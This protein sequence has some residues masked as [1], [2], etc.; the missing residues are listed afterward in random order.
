MTD[1][2]GKPVTGLRREDFTVLEDGQPQTL[3]AF[4][5]GDF[6]LSV[7]VAVD[8]SFSMG[9]KQLPTAVER[10]ADASSASCGRRISR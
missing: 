9:A 2:A 1:Q 6:P 3:S 10:G 8:R 5:E 7:A 4:A